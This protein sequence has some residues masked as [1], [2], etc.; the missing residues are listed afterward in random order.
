MRFKALILNHPL[1]HLVLGA[2]QLGLPYGI[3]NTAGQPDAAEAAEIIAAGWRRG[4]RWFDTAQAYGTSEAVLGEA[5][6][7]L[8]IAAEACV[9]S[10]LAPEVPAADPVSVC[11]AVGGSLQRLRVPKLAGLMLHR[12]SQLDAWEPGIRRS[13]EAA[14]DAGLIERVGISVYSTEH[15]LNAL[16]APGIDMI[17]VAANVFDRRMQRGGVFQR[18]K[19]LGKAVFIRSVY[20]Q[21]LALMPPEAAPTGISRAVEAVRALDEFCRERR[22][23]RRQ[24]AIDFVRAA[25]PDARL[26]LGAETSRQVAENCDCFAGDAIAPAFHD[27]WMKR[28]PEDVEA[29]IDP[30]FWP[31][32]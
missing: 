2:V 19:D 31:S 3:A 14:K 1:E 4:L 18:A 21:G 15:A 20:L 30:R 11:D 16:A 6:E 22:I 8:G 28:W 13:F 9:I 32:A 12:E 7:K 24:F 26:V 5:F 23:D 17:Q 29:L 27:Q 25:A 10:K